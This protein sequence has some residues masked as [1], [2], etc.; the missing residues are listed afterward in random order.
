MKTIYNVYSEGDGDYEV[1]GMFDEDGNALGMWSC[2]DAR[3][4]GE[5]FDGFLEALGIK[6]EYDMTGRSTKFKKLRKKLDEWA[7]QY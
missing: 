2:S 4:E 1:E 3:W 7:E 5:Y 6:V